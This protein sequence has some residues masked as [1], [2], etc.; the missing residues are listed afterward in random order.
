MMLVGDPVIILEFLG[1][2][3]FLE[4]AIAKLC[5]ESL[6]SRKVILSNYKNV[7]SAFHGFV[8]LFDAHDGAEVQKVGGEGCHDLVFVFHSFLE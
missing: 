5:D 8:G 6:S 2:V 3:E 4:D 7:T 1:W